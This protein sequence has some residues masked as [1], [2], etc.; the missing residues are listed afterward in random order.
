MNSSGASVKTGASGR[1][2]RSARARGGGLYHEAMLKRSLA[3]PVSATG[4]DVGAALLAELDKRMSGRCVAEGYV[5]PE[6]IEIVQHSGSRL[7]GDQ[8]IFAADVACQVCLPVEGMEIQCIDE[9]VTK[10]GVR[11]KATDEP[12]PV[13]VFV[14][15]D[16]NNTSE[17]F[18]KVVPGDRIRARVIGQRFELNDPYVSVIAEL[19]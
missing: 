1:S 7:V 10:A 3:L 4:R 19:A 17:A 8:A 14:A 15:R 2:E 13:V 12:S 11:A 6:S 18:S 5:K 9:D 16:H